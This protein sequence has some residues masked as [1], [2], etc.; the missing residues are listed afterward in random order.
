M[1]EALQ[2]WKKISGKCLD[3]APDE[4]KS[5]SGEQLGSEK[6]GDKRS[7]LSDLMKKEASDGSILSPDSA[8]KA[9]GGLPEKA[10]VML[11]KKAPA[12]SDKDFNPEFFQRLERGNPWK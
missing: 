7:N 3:G 10:A 6:N 8:S 4:S 1:T 11:K 5:S 2:L 12:L 9:K